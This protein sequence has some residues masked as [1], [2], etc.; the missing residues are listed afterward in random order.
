MPAPISS[1]SN[2]AGDAPR[3]SVAL[4]RVA[5]GDPEYLFLK[6]AENPKDPWSGHYALP[7]GRR[8]SGDRDLLDTCIRETLEECGLSLNPAHLLQ[9][10]PP[11]MAGKPSGSATVVAPF[12]FEIP[13]R[14]VL[15][16]DPE[17]IAAF[18]WLPLSYLLDAG[19]HA[20]A[21]LSRH[22]PHLSFPCL[23]VGP[24]GEG[25][26]IWGFTYG[27]LQ[28]SLPGFPQAGISETEATPIKGGRESGLPG[29]E[30]AEAGRE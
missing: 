28:R 4:I 13:E 23:R 3:A 26:A 6:R 21:C 10:L 25:E 2:P 11:A 7:G 12:L 29:P 1:P 17:E 19:N 27:V 18:H 22:Y 24:A 9:S 20:R 5:C 30:S 14:P 16:L 15:S 8:E